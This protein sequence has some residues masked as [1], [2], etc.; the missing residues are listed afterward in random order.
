MRQAFFTA[1]TQ[2]AR[3]DSSPIALPS[4]HTGA[5]T[6]PT[7]KPLPAIF[8]ASALMPSSLMSMFVCGS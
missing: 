5:T 2:P 6:E 8:S 7:T 3:L 4:N 1:V